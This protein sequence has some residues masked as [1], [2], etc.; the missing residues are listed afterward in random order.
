M[1]Q[2]AHRIFLTEPVLNWRGKAQKSVFLGD[3]EFR[4]LKGRAALEGVSARALMT[5]DLKDARRL[6]DGKA[7]E[8][9]KGALKY[10]EGRD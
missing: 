4:V 2:K 8:A 6:L 3:A 7:E 9:L 10:V 1:A 5:R